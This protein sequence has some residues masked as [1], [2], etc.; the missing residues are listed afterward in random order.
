[1]V[2]LLTRFEPQTNRLPVKS[3]DVV[4]DGAVAAREVCQLPIRLRHGV[5]GAAPPPRMILCG[6]ELPGQ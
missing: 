2:K 1:M 5:P 6:A 4:Y 3:G